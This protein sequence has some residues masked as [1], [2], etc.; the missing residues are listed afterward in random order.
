MGRADQHAGARPPVLPATL[1]TFQPPLLPPPR[2]ASGTVRGCARPVAS[3]VRHGEPCVRFAPRRA[4]SPVL[5]RVML[6]S[7]CVRALFWKRGETAGGVAAQEG[8]FIS[9]DHGQ[10][11]DT[12]P[13]FQMGVGSFEEG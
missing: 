2:R 7:L 12:R 4:E 8:N 5:W 11:C 13:S 3:R 6:G 1:C 10:V 9:V